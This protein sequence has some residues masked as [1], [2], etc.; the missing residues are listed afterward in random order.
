MNYAA[1]IT[2]WQSRY[3]CYAVLHV[4]LLNLR[5]KSE[6][7]TKE[8][9]TQR[10]QYTHEDDVP[11]FFRN[12][13]VV[14]GVN[15]GSLFASSDEDDEQNV[16]DGWVSKAMPWR[17]PGCDQLVRFLDKCLYD[18]LPVTT[19]SRPQSRRGP[20]T[21]KLTHKIGRKL[22]RNDP[23]GQRSSFNADQLRHHMNLQL[24]KHSYQSDYNP[25]VRNER[26]YEIIA[27]RRNDPVIHSICFL[28]LVC[29]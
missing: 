15:A 10:A 27:R 19:K 17:T 21:S 4:R 2:E 12:A 23:V 13:E 29:T 1:W 22:E 18:R 8:W 7:R 20:G 16:R 25:L 11:D 9:V 6:S 14:V 26:G 28:L 3:C 24:R 5:Q